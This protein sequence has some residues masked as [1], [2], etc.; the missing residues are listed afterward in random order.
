MSR[1]GRRDRN[2]RQGVISRLVNTDYDLVR[3][4]NSNINILRFRLARFSDGWT[5]RYLMYHIYANSN[6]VRTAAMSALGLPAEKIT[7]IKEVRD[8]ARLG[9]PSIQPRN[10]ARLSLELDEDQKVIVTIGRQDFQKG[11]RYLLEALAMLVS[12]HP[13][14]VLLV[15][16]R[17]TS[18][19]NLKVSDIALGCKIRCNFLDTG[20]TFPKSWQRRICLSFPPSMR[21]FPVP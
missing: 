6:V 5:A 14:L 12:N 18:R 19:V 15:A 16:G 10:R 11:Q 3:L 2:F 9:K 7:V 20:R 1:A 21:G 13:H 4:K 8:A 17:E